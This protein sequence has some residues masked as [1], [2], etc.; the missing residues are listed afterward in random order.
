MW[1]GPRHHAGC[2]KQLCEK[3]MKWINY[4]DMTGSVNFTSC[5]DGC[6]EEAHGA[7]AFAVW[8]AWLWMWVCTWGWFWHQKKKKFVD[9]EVTDDDS[10]RDCKDA[11]IP[12]ESAPVEQ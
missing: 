4:T 7:F 1:C 10:D 11:P 6:A 2:G 5:D 12:V 3:H 8:G 9:G